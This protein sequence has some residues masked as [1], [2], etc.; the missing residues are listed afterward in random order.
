MSSPPTAYPPLPGTLDGL[1]AWAA[2]PVDIPRGQVPTA[3]AEF[4]APASWSRIDLIS[5]LHLTRESFDATLAP[6]MRHLQDD[7]ADALFI[8]GDLFEAWIGDDVV[9]IDPFAQHC[10]DWLRSLGAEMPLFFMHGNRD[11]L[12]GRRLLDGC[13]ITLLDDPS[14]LTFDRRRWLLT[15]GDAL[16]TTDHA[17][18]AF[19]AQVRQPGFQQGFLS[20]P[21]G[22]RIEVARKMRERS[23]AHQGSRDDIADVDPCL[24]W[25]WLEAADAPVMVH[26]HTHRP[27]RHVSGPTADSA[28]VLER[29]VMSDWDVAAQSPRCEV[30]RL[31]RGGDGLPSRLGRIDLRRGR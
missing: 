9:A 4:S 22:R 8:L 16:C 15:H 12:V 6:L 14:V 21:I 20:M 24:A 7:R 29:W 25:R 26:G 3:F 30:L 31:E 23:E 18:M 28:A 19:R 10:A 13:L 5:D 2:A 27:D 17:Y 1:G 11:F